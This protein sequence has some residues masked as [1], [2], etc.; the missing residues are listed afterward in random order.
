MIPRKTMAETMAEQIREAILAGAWKPGTTIPT[1]P[2][3]AKQFGITE[4]AVKM[5]MS[6]LRK[7]YRAMLREEI[8]QTVSSEE[9]IDDEIRDL[10]DSLR[11][12]AS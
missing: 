9:E 3:L 8:A 2:E 6:R 7:R 12:P 11:K 5:A 4:A 10:F 1:E